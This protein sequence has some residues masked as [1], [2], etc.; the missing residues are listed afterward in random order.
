M[1]FCII[2]FVVIVQFYIFCR[3]LIYVK[4]FGNIGTLNKTNLKHKHQP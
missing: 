3:Y 2:L 1:F 4:C